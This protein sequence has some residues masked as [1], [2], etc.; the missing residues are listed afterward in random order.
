MEITAGAG[1][2]PDLIHPA[3]WGYPGD[4]YLVDN[5]NVIMINKEQENEELFNQDIVPT[6][7]NPRLGAGTSENV[8]EDDYDYDQDLAILKSMYQC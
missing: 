8:Q 7:S 3:L 4:Y 1:H 5:V 2:Y 6:Y